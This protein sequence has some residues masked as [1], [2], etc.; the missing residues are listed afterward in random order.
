MTNERWLRWVITKHFRDRGF[1]V[2]MKGVRVG[3]ATVDGEVVGNN[4]KL[5]LEIKRF[6]D[7][8]CS[9]NR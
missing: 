4:W 2:N 1:Y 9:T 7:I 6:E 5:A 3:N 8:V